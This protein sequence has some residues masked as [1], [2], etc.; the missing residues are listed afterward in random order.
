MFNYYDLFVK[1]GA[2]EI[3]DFSDDEKFDEFDK[4]YK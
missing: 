3:K 4:I 1:M 2:T